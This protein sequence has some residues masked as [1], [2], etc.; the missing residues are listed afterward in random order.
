M[1]KTLNPYG[2]TIIPLGFLTFFFF[3]PLGYLIVSGILNFQHWMNLWSQPLIVASMWFT[4]RQAFWSMLFALLIGV[5]AGFLLGRWQPYAKH[6]VSAAIIVPFLMPP[7]AVIIGFV[8]LFQSG[9]IIAN[10]LGVNQAIIP[11]FGSQISIILAHVLYNISLVTRITAS[12]FET[13]DLR[14]HEIAGIYNFSWSERLFKI[15]I[16]HIKASLL[17]AGLLV[18]LYSFNS[19]AIVLLL[20]Q[21]KY[22]TLEVL[23]FTRVTRFLDFD[24]AI[25]LVLL[26]LIINGVIIL[27]YLFLS[28]QKSP[29]GRKTS[30]LRVSTKQRVIATS[31]LGVVILITWAP[32][33]ATVYQ[34]I[35]LF[36]DSEAEIQ[37]ELIS[38]DYSRFLG[39]S[40]LRVI[41][42]TL[43]FG[44]VTA[45]VVIIFCGLLINLV[46]KRSKL[47]EISLSFV[48]ILPM[49]TSAVT[50]AFGMFLVYQ[51]RIDFSENVWV[52]LIGAHIMAALPFA[53]RTVISAWQE[54]VQE[55][56]EVA[57]IYTDNSLVILRNIIIPLLKGAII[58]SFIFSFAISIGEFGSSY[59]LAR[60]DWITISTAIGKLFTSRS[61]LLPTFFASILGLVSFLAFYS[62]ERIAKLEVQ[63]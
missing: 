51:S 9:G 16:P 54:G 18:F 28:S 50:I 19:F 26:Q 25:A 43:G 46:H 45:F 36:F 56:L 47:G 38:S 59:L 37:Q 40:P 24:T 55:Q 49:V 4:L 41:A 21:V 52:F 44:I 15:T 3:I 23:I 27:T 29:Y 32:M 61:S 7:I 17:S 53:F 5:P 11:I 12:A 33:I 8:V 2:F 39:T 30:I 42:N 13:E 58:V 48:L 10:F 14:Y 63:I 35:R 57:Q 22:Q 20:G 6:S 62:V 34:F 1:T 31:V 60:G